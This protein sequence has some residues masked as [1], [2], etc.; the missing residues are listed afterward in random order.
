MSAIGGQTAGPNGLKFV[1]RT[2]EYPG[3]T[4]AKFFSSKFKMFFKNFNCFEKF[5]C[6][7]IPRA[8]PV[9]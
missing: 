3:K 9:N 6:F 2:L 1:E 7:K 5:K 8:R 4:K